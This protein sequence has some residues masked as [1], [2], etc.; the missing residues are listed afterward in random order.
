MQTEAKLLGALP[1]LSR[2]SPVQRRHSS[3]KGS[4]CST[5]PPEIKHLLKHGCNIH[6]NQN[7]R[8]R[9]SLLVYIIVS[10]FGVSL[11]WGNSST[12]LS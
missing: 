1:L 4:P 6:D 8:N 11:I 10:S 2:G 3:K 12:L 9:A 5:D 7:T